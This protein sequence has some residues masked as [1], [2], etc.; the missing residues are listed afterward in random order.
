MNVRAGIDINETYTVELYGKNLLNDKTL[1]LNGGTTS[2]QFGV[3]EP[4]RKWFTE[5]YQKPEFGIRFTADF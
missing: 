3:P 2:S 4:D 5:P 1:G